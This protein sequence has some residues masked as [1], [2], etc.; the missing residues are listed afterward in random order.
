MNNTKANET[1]TNVTN[2]SPSCPIVSQLLNPTI[3]NESKSKNNK[4]TF[5]R[6]LFDEIETNDAY[7][8]E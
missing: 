6:L 2:N 3:N 7:F 8:E 4:Q 5:K 1:N